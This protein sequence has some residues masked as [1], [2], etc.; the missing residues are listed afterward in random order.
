VTGRLSLIPDGVLQTPVTVRAGVGLD[1]SYCHPITGVPLWRLLR[2]E[3]DPSDP[4]RVWFAGEFGRGVGV[5][6]G[7]SSSRSNQGHAH[8][9]LFARFGIPCRLRPRGSLRRTGPRF[10][11]DRAATDDLPPSTGDG[12]ARR[13][14]FHRSLHRH[15]I[16]RACAGGCESTR[17]RNRSVSASWHISRSIGHNRAGLDGSVS[18]RSTGRRGR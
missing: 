10:R 18:T 5:G 15:A 12:L 7:P 11:L 6:W 8:P 9:E 2:G 17:G 13:F 14:E 1:R 3:R 16:P 4:T